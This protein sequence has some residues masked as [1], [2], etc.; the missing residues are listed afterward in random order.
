MIDISN[1]NILYLTN[2]KAFTLAEILV[3]LTI[4]GIISALTIP[5]LIKNYQE[6]QTVTSVK[7][8]YSDMNKAFQMATVNK[9]KIEELNLQ[10]INDHF[11][12]IK[13]Y[14]KIVKI[15]GT[16]TSDTS[17]F[18][19]GTYKTLINRDWNRHPNMNTNNGGFLKF[20]L[21]DGQAVWMWLSDK[22]CKASYGTSAP[23]Q[24]VCSH[25]GVD[26]NGHKPPNRLGYDTFYFYI[27]KYGIYP[28]GAEE[29]NTYG[30]ANYCNKTTT[31]TDDRN[32][33]A[34]SSWIL[35]R[36]NMDYTK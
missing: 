27:T 23:L 24:N 11:E 16:G 17:C 34:C 6:H 26:I 22:K 9:G 4:I 31:S 2:K 1:K 10:N 14:L 35:E 21:S 30:K 19:N 7:K 25:I 18:Y 8:F 5:T 28:M 20:V 32:G 15:C 3:T 36:G 33:Y 12:Y 13:P 29:D